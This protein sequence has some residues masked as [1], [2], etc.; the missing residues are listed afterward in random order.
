MPE[1]NSDDDLYRV[2][3]IWLGPPAATMPFRAR[4]VAWGVGI[5]LF[6]TT[7][8]LARI[9]FP[10]TFFSLAW[11]AVIAVTLTRLIC[12]KITHER[13]LSAVLT[14]FGREITTP[15][16]QHHATG[17]AAATTDLRVTAHRARPT[18]PA[19]DP[20]AVGTS[21]GH[22]TSREDTRA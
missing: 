6:L 7:F 12:S 10:F 1:I 11:S 16:Q 3:G 20:P 5:A 18:P 15:R 17:G 4:Y 22:R 19:S 13:P 21:T 9:W 2:N 14:M 8:A